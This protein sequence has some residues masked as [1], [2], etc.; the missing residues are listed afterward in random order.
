[1]NEKEIAK[2]IILKAI[3][4]NAINVNDYPEAESQID[5]IC[6]AYKKVL[7]TVQEA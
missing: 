7:K 3:D 5:A 2:D 6:S 4:H 1:M